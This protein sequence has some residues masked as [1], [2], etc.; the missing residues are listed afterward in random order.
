M[1]NNHSMSRVERSR[2][3]KVTRYSIRKYSFGAASVAVAAL[4]MFLGNGAV[5]AQEPE[6]QG[7][8][9]V[10]TTDS[11]SAPESP[12]T[13]A[14]QPIAEESTKPA[15]PEVT[16][17][18]LGKKAENTEPKAGT[19]AIE[20]T[21]SRDPRNGK[22]LE[23]GEGFRTA[24]TAA[25]HEPTTVNVGNLSYTLE[26]SDDAKKEIYAYNEEDTD[27]SIAVNSTVGKI[28]SASVKGGSG[29]YM[30]KNKKQSDPLEAQE[31]DG[32]G[33]TYTSIVND[34]QGPATLKITGKPNDTFK[35]LKDYTK[36][37]NQNAVLGDRY[38]QLFNDNGEQI[39][40]GNNKTADGYF[41]MV[42]KSQTYKYDIKDLT[43]ERRITVNDID[44]IT[45]TELTS[46]KS[47]LQLEHS[48]KS[49]DARFVGGSPVANPTSLIDTVAVS[50]T[51]PS[52]L[53]VTYVDGS[54]DT[55]EKNKVLNVRPKGTIPFSNPATKE[56]YV[57]KG[58]ETNLEFGV[59]DDSGKIK[60]LRIVQAKG[61]VGKSGAAQGQVNNQYGLTMTSET[62]ED[63][64]VATTDHPAITRITRLGKNPL[65]TIKKTSISVVR[66]ARF[67]MSWFIIKIRTK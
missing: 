17:P 20:N 53:V 19:N 65:L 48:K 29:Q 13:P 59:T 62:N 46:I 39:S 9:V 16:T 64:I 14:A 38:L 54:V 8:Q 3:E 7:S 28:T 66:D 31:I 37:E 4:F 67:L 34:T 2:R 47:S 15:A 49:K 44:N 1:E 18:T 61:L 5:S 50:T 35:K 42:V 57:Y 63:G 60:D 6:I 23:K 12:S 11:Q 33:W 27:I 40:G 21:G 32:F 55:I 45:P 43:D 56:I 58:E 30:N 10:N 41:K 26:F 24:A 36:D 52:K 25:K 22:E 51:E